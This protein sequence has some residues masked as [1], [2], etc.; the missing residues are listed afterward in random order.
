M[1][2]E[3]K[4]RVNRETR[5]I[6]IFRPY[7]DNALMYNFN[8]SKEALAQLLKHGQHDINSPKT[9]CIF[10]LQRYACRENESIEKFSYRERIAIE[11]KNVFTLQQDL[12]HDSSKWV[13]YGNAL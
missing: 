8:E 9:L 12:G 5:N 11:L 6:T 4:K 2:Q 10:M 13:E 1:G 3:V 7:R